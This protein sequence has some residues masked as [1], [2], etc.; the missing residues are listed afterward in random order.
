[1]ASCS[2]REK[3][4][5][6]GLRKDGGIWSVL[7]RWARWTPSKFWRMRC[8]TADI[9]ISRRA[10]EPGPLSAHFDGRSHASAAPQPANQAMDMTRTETQAVN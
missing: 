4:A 7:R 3:V 9:A 1:M 10:V 2:F 8:Q 5:R 6:R